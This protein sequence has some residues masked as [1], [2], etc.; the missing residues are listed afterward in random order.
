MSEAERGAVLRRLQ[1]GRSDPVLLLAV[2]GGIFAEGVDYPGN[3]LSG[4]I[5]IGPALPRF[6]TEQELIRA[7]Y[8]A[9]YAS[10]FAYAYLYPG[11]NRVVQSAGRVIRSETDVGIIVLIDKRFTYSNYA[12]LLP[13]HWYNKTPREL[14]TRDYQQ[15]LAR[16]WSTHA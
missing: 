7:Y 6:D 12:T 2:Q 5:I 9:K 10:G 1:R 13:S 15:D 3:M 4:V 11:M 14:I 8:E 16:F